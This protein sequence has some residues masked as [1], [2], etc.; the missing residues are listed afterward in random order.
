MW[1][2]GNHI[3]LK[4]EAMMGISTAY[5]LVGM[6]LLPI[7]TSTSNLLLRLRAFEDSVRLYAK[8]NNTSNSPEKAHLAYQV[9]KEEFHTLKL[10][11][12]S[13]GY[14]GSDLSMLKSASASFKKGE[15]VGIFG[16]SGV[17]KSTLLNI[18]S[19]LIAPSKGKLLFNDLPVENEHQLHSIVGYVPQK[20]TAI[21]GTILENIILEDVEQLSSKNSE[22]LKEIIELTGLSTFVDALP[23]GLYTRLDAHTLSISGGQWQRI[24]VARAIS[25]SKDI[26]IFDEAT[27]ALDEKSEIELINGIRKSN[28]LNCLILVSHRSS[29]QKICDRVYTLC[30][31]GRLEVG[32]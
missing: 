3:G 2:L 12:V 9:T 11:N 4:P 28:F 16:A 25:H 1:T 20:T 15:I 5:A 30:S 10:M 26:I 21:S 18:I 8:T 7:V 17:G 29:T 32:S 19:G 6:R 27:S 23:D 13:F 31:N 24:A 14:Q 22:K